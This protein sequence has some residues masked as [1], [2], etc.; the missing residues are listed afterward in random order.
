MIA[1]KLE[2]RDRKLCAETRDQMIE[3]KAFARLPQ[4][5]E[6]MPTD[7]FMHTANSLGFPHASFT[8]LFCEGV[9]RRNGNAIE[10]WA[11]E[12]PAPE[13]KLLLA[14]ARCFKRLLDRG[15]F[16]MRIPMCEGFRCC[17]MPL[18]DEMTVQDLKAVAAVCCGIL[19]EKLKMTHLSEELTPP[20]MLVEKGVAPGSCIIISKIMGH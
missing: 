8:I 12:D 3:L 2:A 6:T 20:G 13:I 9:L 16:A 14:H 11:P 15:E 18:G 17:I 19:S 5:Q 4:M 10:I 7:L 1:Q